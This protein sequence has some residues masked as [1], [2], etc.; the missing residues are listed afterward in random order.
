MRKPLDGFGRSRQV[1]MVTIDV[2]T[3]HDLFPGYQG[4]EDSVYEYGL[5]R[6]EELLAQEG[7][8]ATLFVAGNDLRRQST[9]QKWIRRFAEGGHEIA[10]HS[11]SHPQGFAFLPRSRK[12]AEI[13]DAGKTIGDVI[14][15]PPVGF[16]APGWNVDEE[17]LDILEEHSYLYDS[18]VF[19]TWLSGLFKLTYWLKKRVGRMRGDR[20]TM[21]RW[22]YQ[23]AP[24]TPYQPGRPLWRRGDRRL[25]EIPLMTVPG[26]RLPFFG[27]FSF[28]VGEGAHRACFNLIRQTS[29]PLNY[30]LHGVEFVDHSSDGM[31]DVLNEFKG[32]YI[33]HTLTLS[34][35]RKQLFLQKTFAMFRSSYEFVTMETF[36]RMV[37][38]SPPM[39]SCHV[40]QRL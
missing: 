35:P 38:E 5:P 17:T 33:P 25:L 14:G 20:T 23:F 22:S 32:E 29:W 40:G 26:I 6:L 16:R 39:L 9:N 3:L 7:V 13:V 28:L 2:D 11:T 24:A 27:T 37:R 19:P 21:G 4:S 15:R 1:A 10:N 8:R 36:A 12:E 30:S 18:S 31:S 34:W